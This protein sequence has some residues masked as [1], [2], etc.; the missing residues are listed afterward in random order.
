[1]EKCWGGLRGFKAEF[2][3]LF[4]P[5]QEETALRY[6]SSTRPAYHK[7]PCHDNRLSLENVSRSPIKQFAR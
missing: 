2:I 4:Q 5:T 6:F 3:F 7:A 1:M